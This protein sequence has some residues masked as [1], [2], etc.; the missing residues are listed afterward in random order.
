MKN[1][2]HVPDVLE[3]IA[4]LPADDV[5]TSPKLAN[6]VLDTLPAEI[7]T[8]YPDYRW[9]DPAAKSGVF[10]REAYSRL[11]EGLVGHLPDPRKRRDHILQ[12]MLFGAAT[13]SLN[14]AIARRS[15]YQSTDASG[16]GLLDNELKDIFCHFDN[17][18]G[19]IAF[20]QTEHSLD[21]A[22]KACTVCR[23]PGT[24]V[25]E[26]RENFA[27]S[28]I[29]H[30]YPGEELSPMKFDVIIGNP[31]YQIGMEDSAGNRTAN[32]T[33]L[34]NLFVERA[35]DMDPRYVL[36]I[37]PSRWFAGG[38]GLSSFR[39]RMI[40]DRRLRSIFDIPNAK[41]AFPTVEVKG[42]VSYFLWDRDWDGDCTFSSLQ[43]GTV[44]SSDTRD[45][46][47]Y[48][49]VILRDS[50]GLQI[51]DKV[52][53]SEEF[54]LGLD[55]LISNRDPFGQSITSNFKGSKPESFPGAIPLIY[56]NQIGYVDLTQLERNHSWVN[57]WKVIIPK[58]SDGVWRESASVLGEPIALAPGSAC[59]Q[60]YLVAGTFESD[61]E[62]RNLAEFL[63]TKFCRFLVL[64]KKITQ[65][66]TS[67][68][69]SFVP[70]LDLSKRWTDKKLYKLFRLD[71]AEIAYIEKSVG[72]R[73]WIDSLN[74]PIPATHVPG[75]R[76]YKVA[77]DY[78]DPSED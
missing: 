47:K 50:K 41:N 58:A 67:S 5:Y 7:W 39:S 21:K 68:M 61:I 42:G 14:G 33:P 45:L 3:T 24:L 20:V 73:E 60:S 52:L 69:F 63:T 46:R 54:A 30:T 51:V 74:S 10:L 1:R 13:T 2:N 64:Q 16:Q 23:A 65:N 26:N 19:N 6:L 28:F 44:V 25:R 76:K 15:L 37:T 72:P 4:Q 75:G 34:Y 66:M 18:D 36:M 31:P 48:G 38:K 8:N 22:E 57:M 49:D 56:N 40:A 12:N 35:I 53:S 17:A 77:V 27:Y 70:R 62:A 71:D 29:H 11:M 43:D 55:G 32:I 9:L 78:D 59:T